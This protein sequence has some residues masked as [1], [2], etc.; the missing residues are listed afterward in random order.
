[1]I[2]PSGNEE[3]WWHHWVDVGCMVWES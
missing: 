3:T 1:L 2:T